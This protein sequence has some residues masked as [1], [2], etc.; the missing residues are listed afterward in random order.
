[1]ELADKSTGNYKGTVHA[2]CFETLGRVAGQP[3]SDVTGGIESQWRGHSQRPVLSDCPNSFGIGHIPGNPARH[4]R[5]GTASFA[6]WAAAC[7]CACS[8]CRC[9]YAAQPESANTS[10]QGV[11][12]RTV[13][14][15]PTR[16]SNFTT[17][18]WGLQD[19]L[20]RP[21]CMKA[22]RNRAIRRVSASPG[23]ST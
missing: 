16:D 20:P 9:W 21:A 1:V 23:S 19:P 8:S 11:M 5:S 7:A 12:I 14:R 18:S 6:A 17:C 10:T 4:R 13:P 2:D 22:Y 15:A 3:V